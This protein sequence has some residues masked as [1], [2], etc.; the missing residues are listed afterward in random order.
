MLNCH[1]IDFNSVT[2]T[3][4]RSLFAFPF[5]RRGSGLE[6]TQFP[7]NVWGCGV[8]NYIFYERH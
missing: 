2:A 5:P 6:A 1:N 3:A 7:L 4:V 8:E